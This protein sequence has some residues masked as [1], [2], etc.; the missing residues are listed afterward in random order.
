MLRSL[1]FSFIIYCY[2]YYYCLCDRLS[3]FLL[4]QVNF[5]INKQLMN[6]LSD[7]YCVCRFG[8]INLANGNH[9]NCHHMCVFMWM[10]CLLARHVV[11]CAVQNAMKTFAIRH[12]VWDKEQFSHS[13]IH[14]ENLSQPILL[15]R[16]LWVFSLISYE[17]KWKWSCRLT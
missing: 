15:L 6:V 1:P 5:I 8:L 4:F 16:C 10:G 17:D 13:D 2:C 12:S 7:T 9:R 3:L 11:W 14:A